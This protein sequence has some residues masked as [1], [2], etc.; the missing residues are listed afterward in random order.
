MYILLCGY[1]PFYSTANSNDLDAGMRRQIRAGEY[2]FDGPEW[3]E[4]SEDAKS[5]IRRML[6]VNPAQRIT[7]DEI[8]NSS[9]FNQP[10]SARPIDMSSLG[11]AENRLQMEVSF[12]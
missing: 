12:N 11:D 10:A 8:R 2:A 1:P 6:T 9:W 3:N 7:I 4:V 5:T